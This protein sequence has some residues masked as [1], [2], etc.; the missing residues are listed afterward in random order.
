MAYI[1]RMPKL[2]LEM[3]EGTVLEWHVDVSE[4][5][6]ADDPVVEI[7][8]EKTTE[9]VEAREAGAL[10]EVLI[11]AG[12]TVPPGAPLGIVA[13]PETDV[14]DLRAEAEAE[15]ETTDEA[16]EPAESGEEPQS[17]AAGDQPPASEPDE[18]GEAEPVVRASPK[19]KKRAEELGVDLGAVEGTGPGGAI[20]AEDVE[21]AEEASETAPT[22]GGAGRTVRDRETFTGMRATIARRL[23]ESY[24][25]AVHVTIHRSADASALREATEAADEALDADVSMTDLLLLALSET[26]GTFPAFN[27]TYEDGEHVRYEEH[28]INIAVDVDEG[29]LTPVIPTVDQKT[30][31]EV[32]ETR[33]TVTERTL[34]GEYTMDDLSGG[35]FTVSNLGHLGVEA[36]NP[37]INPPQIAILGVDALSERV[38]MVDGEAT[39]QPMLPLDLSFDHRVVDGADAARFMAALVERLENPWSLLV[40]AGDGETTTDRSSESEGR[41]RQGR[42]RSGSDVEGVALVEDYDYPYD[43]DEIST[44]FAGTDRRVLTRNEAESEGVFLIEDYD[45]PFGLDEIPTP[46]EIMLGSLQS[47]LALT[48]RNVAM[49]AGV[50]IEAVTVD[51]VL[52]PETG[53]IE[54]ID[55]VVIV[56]AP[57]VG[58]DALADLID[59]AEAECHVAEVLREDLPVEISVERP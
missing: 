39:A 14:S 48:L 16:T 38:R 2:G 25:E 54:A 37:I 47:C 29:L 57:E 24:R 42:S 32:A 3:E 4:T 22:E 11:D 46:P 26:L 28:N 52:Q 17:S 53:S 6:S 21:R 19:A 43:L 34:S 30:L 51:G 55:L 35:T 8:S 23:G 33:R 44:A 20:T 9:T 50:T 10:R 36:F 58:D 49:E 59:E 7:E 5:V 1:V 40:G 41:Q 56:D 45:Y 31:P 27:G 18:S 12:T 13:D 15:L